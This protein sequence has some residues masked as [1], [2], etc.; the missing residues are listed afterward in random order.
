MVDV[1]I[2]CEVTGFDVEFV[3]GCQELT[4]RLIGGW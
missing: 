3:R 4:W 2:G 1:E